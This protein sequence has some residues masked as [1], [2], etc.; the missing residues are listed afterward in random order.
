M[1]LTINPFHEFTPLKKQLFKRSTPLIY[2]YSTETNSST[3]CLPAGSRF[4]VAATVVNNIP[5]PEKS[6]NQFSE[7]PSF[8]KNSKYCT[9]TKMSDAKPLFIAENRAENDLIKCNDSE[10]FIKQLYTIEKLKVH[11]TLVEVAEQ[12]TVGQK[13]LLIDKEVYAKLSLQKINQYYTQLYITGTV[14]LTAE[15]YS[16]TVDFQSED[17][18]FTYLINYDKQGNYADHLLIG[19]SDYV[20]SFTPI[21]PIFAPG[22]V[23]VNATIWVDTNVETSGYR[24]YDSKRYVIN[25]KGQFVAMNYA[26]SYS[27]TSM[28]SKLI[29]TQTIK[30]TSYANPRLRLYLDLKNAN[31]PTGGYGTGLYTTL[32]SENGSEA[33]IPMDLSAVCGFYAPPYGSFI[34]PIGP[35]QKLF[36]AHTQE[37]IQQGLKMEFYL[38]DINNDGIDDLIL[39]ITD[40]SYV[41]APVDYVCFIKEGGTWNYSVFNEVAN[42]FSKNYNIPY[43]MVFKS[44]YK[45]GT[46]PNSFSVAV[47][48]KEGLLLKKH[49][50][51]IYSF[52]IKDSEKRVSIAVAEKGTYIV[53]RFGT[54]T[55]IELEYVAELTDETKKFKY[56]KDDRTLVPPRNYLEHLSFKKGD[57]DYS[58]FNNY[59]ESTPEKGIDIPTQ[60]GVGIRVR[61]IKTGKISVLE[62]DQNSIQG[63]LGLAKLSTK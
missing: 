34:G 52:K 58:V 13:K 35:L 3:G 40:N 61:N 8:L 36:F 46:P 29:A 55:K 45:S 27:P 47:E 14:D 9:P 21:L 32:I 60:N 7:I 39:Q 63:A 50:N 37:G 4:L 12:N 62:A 44:F 15:F 57:Y 20:E 43:E 11:T 17:E 19:R 24:T 28:E 1:L 26:P 53:Y 54:K 18:Y 42:A 48:S 51:L 2:K 56:Y 33:T 10:R 16:I 22:E 31:N 23:Y 6:S 41:V 59:I 5:I 30:S 49:E 25:A 38:K